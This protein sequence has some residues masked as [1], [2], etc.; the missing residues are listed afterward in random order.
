MMSM[1]ALAAI[2]AFVAVLAAAGV[3][4]ADDAP[5]IRTLI[6]RGDFERARIA[7]GDALARD[8]DDDERA[9]YLELFAVV[10]AWDGRR[11]IP[12][13]ARARSPQVDGTRSWEASF[14]VA[15]ALLV[16]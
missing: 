1:R 6:V 7:L 8:L 10:E 16:E 11:G 15:R 13:P 5:P 9:A 2:G 3:V 4:R 14:E 12:R